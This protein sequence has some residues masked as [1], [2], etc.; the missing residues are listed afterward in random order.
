MNNPAQAPADGVY[1]RACNLCE[2]ICGLQ[3][4][5]RGGQVT[6]VR[7]DPQDPLSRGHICPKGTALPDLHAD[8]NRLKKPL[9]RSLEGGRET[10]TELEWDEALDEV[11]GRLRAI[12]EAHG[13]DAVASFQGNP[14]VHNSGT[15]LTA[16][17]FLRALGS[18]NRF[19][20]TSTD[21]LPHHY[22]AAEMLGHPL[23]IPIPDLD[24][25]DFLLMLGANPLTSNGS[26]MTAPNMRE[27]LKAIWERGGRVVLLDPRRTESAQAASEFH[28][29]RPA[30]DA[31]FLMALLNVIFAEGL[32]KLGHLS[33][34]ADG[35]AE[36]KTA[37]EPFAP[38]AVAGHTGIAAEVTRQLARD[39]AAAPHA[40]AYGR[41][42]L[43]VQEF[44][45]LCQWL[46]NVLNAVTCHFDREGGAMFPRPAFDLLMRT[47]KGETHH[48]RYRSRVRGLPEFDGELPN[49]A[50]TEEILT[51]G[52][53]Q[54]RALVTMAGNP[55]LSTPSGH[56]LGKALETLEF[57]VSIDPYLNET[58][59][60]AH[61]ILPPAYGL[62][63]EHYDVIFHHFAVRN[64]ARYN[65]ALFPISAEQRYDHQILGGLTERLTGKSGS[66]PTAR[67]DLGLQHG[68]YKTSLDDL[69]AQPHGIDFGPLQPCLPER[70][71]TADGRLKLAPAL[72]LADLERLEAALTQTPPPLV[73]IG[74]RQLRSNNSWMH[75]IPRLMRG[76]DR[77]TLQLHPHDAAGWHTGDLIEVTSRTGRVTVPL[78]ITEDVMQGVACLP[79]GF[80]HGDPKTRLG[81]AADHAGASLND[82]TDPERLD[83]LTGNAA[84][85]GTPITVRAKA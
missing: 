83:T 85:N 52:Q 9:R 74:R 20:A 4:T 37:T 49:A 15:L 67:L 76:P 8:P 56:Q 47:K 39:F 28:F 18:K 43:S 40:V 29:I 41:I 34:F 5:V 30:T 10:W 65:S 23:L 6:D 62:E 79:H 51:A 35:L 17:N 19:T 42:G 59:R 27:R 44:G 82:L 60:H 7:G 80:G 70:L 61:I 31:L 54:I 3:F 14:S 36:L 75:H 55:V 68:P 11:A 2:A 84:L 48:S 24:R 33:D 81:V 53:G 38:E 32:E 22:A 64:T 63:T 72:L 71:L 13:A 26:I 57:M 78:E 25:T 1:F 45:G 66:A 16:G 73:I 12:Q 21:Q 46:V 58:T 77:C 50:L 69:K